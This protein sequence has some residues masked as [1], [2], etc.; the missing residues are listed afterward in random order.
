MAT[1][2]MDGDLFYSGL[3]QIVGDFRHCLLRNP[4]S[5]ITFLPTYHSDQ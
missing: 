3:N 1:Q 4:N 2:N 5:T